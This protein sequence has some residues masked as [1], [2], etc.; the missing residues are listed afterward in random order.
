[1]HISNVIKILPVF[2]LARFEHFGIYVVMFNEIAKTLWKI[3]LLFFF[4]MLAFALVFHALMLNQVRRDITNSDPILNDN[5]FFL[6]GQLPLENQLLL[7]KA[8]YVAWI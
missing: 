7:L 8:T 2:T 1:M 6:K 3:L 4:L 5:F